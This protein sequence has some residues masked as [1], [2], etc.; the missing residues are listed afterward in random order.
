M[1]FERNERN[2]NNNKHAAMMEKKQEMMQ[3]RR[4]AGSIATH[5]PDV[6]SI[7]M[8][9]TYNQK[10]TKSILR[11][12]HFTPSSYA[13]FIVNCLR[14]DCADGG[15]DL[16]QVITTMIR[17]HRAGVK[18]VLVCKGTDPSTNHSDI[19]YEVSVQYT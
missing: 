13:F 3:Q 16:T 5:F 7:D 10:G 6:A 12:F 14:K 18:G 15:F 17:N 11:T 4:E 9:M 2:M 8:N 19:V 1:N